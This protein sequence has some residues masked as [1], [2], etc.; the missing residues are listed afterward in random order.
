MHFTTTSTF[1]SGLVVALNLATTVSAHGYMKY[2]DTAGVR[3]PAWQVG[4]DDYV[5]PTPQRWV[6]RVLDVG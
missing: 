4:Q 1:L 6:R 2:V 5:T 3:Y